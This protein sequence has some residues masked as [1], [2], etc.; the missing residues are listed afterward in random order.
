[1]TAQ[2]RLH[3]VAALFCSILLAVGLVA[4]RAGAFATDRSL[5]RDVKPAK[6]D[7]VQPTLMGGTKSEEPILP[8][9]VISSPSL[10]QE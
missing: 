2:Y 7:Y 3:K 9:G 10:V 8:T 1:M 4:F 5:E 6:N